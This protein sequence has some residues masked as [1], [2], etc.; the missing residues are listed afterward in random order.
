MPNDV[1]TPVPP[2]FTPVPSDAEQ[3][4]LD[5]TP[6]GDARTIT[7]RVGAVSTEF[8]VCRR[9]LRVGTNGSIQEMPDLPPHYTVRPSDAEG[10]WAVEHAYADM[11]SGSDD[12][13]SRESAVDAAW[14]D[15]HECSPEWHAILAPMRGVS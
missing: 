14:E 2:A 6:Q 12:L 9:V 3:A 5:A 7:H 13:P 15:F 1:F 8:T 4:W 10:L 11:G